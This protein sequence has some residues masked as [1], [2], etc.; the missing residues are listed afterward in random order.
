MTSLQGML[1]SVTMKIN[2]SNE[3]F[4]VQAKHKSQGYK[5]R[6]KTAILKFASSP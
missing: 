6:W 1:I 3:F 5:K 4:I 2:T